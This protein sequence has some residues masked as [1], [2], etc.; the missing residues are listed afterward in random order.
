MN[1]KSSCGCA[2]AAW[3]KK[4]VKPQESGELIIT[5]NPVFPGSFHKEL[6]V[7]YNGKE[8]PAKLKIKG[9]VQY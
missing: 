3:S 5:Y 2:V 6:F 4:P 1:V 8:S 7:Y 9:Q